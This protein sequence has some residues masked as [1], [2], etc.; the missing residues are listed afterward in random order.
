M[1]SDFSLTQTNVIKE[2]LGERWDEEIELCIADVEVRIYPDDR[3]LTLCPALV[4]EKEECN[5]AVIKINET[6][7]KN[8]FYYRGSRQF[9]TGIDKYDDL[10]TC[11]KTLLQVQTDFLAQE[12]NNTQNV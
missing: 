3:E 12:L 6:E 5:F 1:I 10:Y 11:V 9:G 8:V 4:W 2:A 7:Y